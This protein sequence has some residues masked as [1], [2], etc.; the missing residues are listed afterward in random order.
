M[1]SL[2][3]N[4]LYNSFYQA[5][6]I[7][8]PL[9]TY[10][11]VARI[12]GPEGIGKVTYA[13][14][15]ASYFYNFALAGIPYFALR[16]ISKV[17]DNK[18][19]LSKKYSQ[20]III[21]TLLALFSAF[22]YMLSEF[23]IPTVVPERILFKLFFINVISEWMQ[24]DW[25]YQGVENYRYI[26]I[27]NILIRLISIIF[28]FI[29]INKKEDYIY[30]AILMIVTS[31]ISGILNIIYSL[32]ITKFSYN[33]ECFSDNFK[34]IFTSFFIVHSGIILNSIDVIMLGNLV[35]DQKQSVGLYNAAFRLLKI[36][37][38]I[39]GSITVVLT[40]RL[41]YLFSKQEEKKI[42]DILNKNVNI[43]LFISI[44]ALILLFYFSK[45]IISI[46]FGNKFINSIET[47][48]ILSFDILFLSLIG[49]LSQILYAK[50]KDKIFIVINIIISIFG[51]LSNLIFIPIYK[52]DGAALATIITRL[53][54]LMILVWINYDYIKK[55]S[56]IK[57]IFKITLANL[58][59]LLVIIII[60]DLKTNIIILITIY[61]I[62]YLIISYNTKIKIFLYLCEWIKNKYLSLIRKM[63]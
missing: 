23:F 16:E 44:P 35:N 12:I 53:L 46:F 5:I 26:T 6:R 29:L 38:S 56:D 31:L 11:Y 42:L 25:F 37:I 14:T 50:H 20:F 58:S 33:L 21:S 52:H 47:L 61:G 32:K 36:I 51:I 17:R 59:A 13:Y 3:A 45:D 57:E 27:R 49:I 48:K 40:P 24:I 9:I 30:Y 34:G 62:C 60:R 18:I 15:Y 4:A 7:I 54:Y 19:V 10:P 55:F 8:F 39:I 28:T 22:A 43:S 1:A 63:K 41:S 2:K